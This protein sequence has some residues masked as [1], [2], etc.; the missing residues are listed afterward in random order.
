MTQFHVPLCHMCNMTL[1]ERIW[2]T[3][4]PILLQQKSRAKKV[5]VYLELANFSKQTRTKKLLFTNT[6]LSLLYVEKKT[7][8]SWLHFPP[9]LLPVLETFPTF[10]SLPYLLL[11]KFSNPFL[12]LTTFYFCFFFS[13][14][15]LY[16]FTPKLLMDYSTAKCWCQ[17]L[18]ILIYWRLDSPI[19]TNTKKRYF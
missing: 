5:V 3:A 10:S 4:K 12:S 7:H 9:S 17:L 19:T 1:E 2:Q 15:C 11:L 8:K 16:S 13:F 14:K 18:K 6:F